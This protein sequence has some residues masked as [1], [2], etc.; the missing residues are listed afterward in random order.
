LANKI[1]DEQYVDKAL[2]ILTDEQKAEFG[3]VREVL[4]AHEEA[5]KA[6]EEEYTKLYVEMAGAAIAR[7]PYSQRQLTY[8]VPGLTAE[9]RK[10]MQTATMGV[11]R[12]QSQEVNRILKEKGIN[13]PG[14]QNREGRQKYYQAMRE[15]RAEV[16]K[17]NGAAIQE[18]I[19][20][21]LS[22]ESAEKYKKLSAALA[23]VIQKREELQSKLAEQL[24]AII[25]AERL[26][27]KAIQ[28][29]GRTQGAGGTVRFNYGQ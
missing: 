23:S 2:A 8:Q 10:A 22:P 26:Q 21:T 17:K 9:E 6:A 19:L 28:W 5:M 11:Y 13:R 27:P 1:L 20:G 16:T 25:G 12:Q 24:E 3:K 4:L 29:Q 14:R 18:K 7:A 15:V